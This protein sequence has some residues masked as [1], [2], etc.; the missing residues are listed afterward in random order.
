MQS[1]SSGAVHRKTHADSGPKYDAAVRPYPEDG[2][3]R[4]RSCPS[5]KCDDR[6]SAVPE[7]HKYV[8]VD[9]GKNTDPETPSAA[10]CG[11]ASSRFSSSL[12]DPV[13]HSGCTPEVGVSRPTSCLP[14]V[15]FPQPDSPTSPRVS[16]SKIERDTSSTAWIFPTVWVMIPPLIG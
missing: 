3:N 5:S 13:P 9:S 7:S 12:P 10:V 2:L 1:R 4:G 16:P 8:S 14:I 6:A 15:D 11:S